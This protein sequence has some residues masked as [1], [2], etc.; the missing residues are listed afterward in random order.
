MWRS[1]SRTFCYCFFMLYEF[2][3]ILNQ[4]FI[5]FF[6]LFCS[7]S[8]RNEE[9]AHV[10]YSQ[11]TKVSTVRPCLL[12]ASKVHGVKYFPAL[13]STSPQNKKAGIMNGPRGTTVVLN[14]LANISLVL[15]S[16]V[17]RNLSAVPHQPLSTRVC[18]LH[19]AP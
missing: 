17:C 3:L 14:L 9:E 11:T 4:I 10:I 12:P 8:S 16:E 6:S 7:F 1:V 19:L 15:I 5:H 18:S 2:W 13:P